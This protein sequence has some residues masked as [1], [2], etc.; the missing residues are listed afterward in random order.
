MAHSHRNTA[1]HREERDAARSAAK[2]NPHSSH[3]GTKQAYRNRAAAHGALAKV[4]ARH[5]PSVPLEVYHCRYCGQYHWGR[6]RAAGP[7]S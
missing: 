4:R 1:A 7:A 6:M 3:C 2:R 5:G